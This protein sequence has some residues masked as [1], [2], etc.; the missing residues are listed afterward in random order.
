MN[1]LSVTDQLDFLTT[2]SARLTLLD[3]A[4]SDYFETGHSRVGVGVE[5]KVHKVEQC[6]KV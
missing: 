4:A 6:R 5:V 1:H 2:C 3:L